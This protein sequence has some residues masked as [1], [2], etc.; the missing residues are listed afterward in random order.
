MRWEVGV[1]RVR[2]GEVKGTARR[3][4]VMLRVG[5]SLLRRVCR[6]DEGRADVMWT[7]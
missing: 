1:R 2:K 7:A 5:G 3:L 6:V 4:N